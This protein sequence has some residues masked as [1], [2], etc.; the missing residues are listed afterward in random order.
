MMKTVRV[1][2]GSRIRGILDPGLESWKTVHILNVHG[3]LYLKREVNIVCGCHGLIQ[4]ML[5]CEGSSAVGL[6]R[7]GPGN[8]M[9]SKPS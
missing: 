9:H 6:E 2:A 1:V 3:R 8:S 7:T 4:K 5:F